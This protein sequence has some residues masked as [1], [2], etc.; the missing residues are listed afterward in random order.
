MLPNGRSASIGSDDGDYFA[1]IAC[2]E[3]HATGYCPLKVA[4]VEHCNLCGLAHYGVARTCPHLNSVTQLR[5]MVEAIK[6]SPESQELKDLAKKRI[7]G[8]IGDL[9]QRKR[10]KH[11]AQLAQEQLLTSAS[12]TVYQKPN[13]GGYSLYGVPAPTHPPW[14]SSNLANGAIEQSPAPNGISTGPSQA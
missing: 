1:C 8:I 2:H 14:Q 7:V 13:G 5:V 4:G 3:K 9:N 11:Q 6:Q 12:K 10:K